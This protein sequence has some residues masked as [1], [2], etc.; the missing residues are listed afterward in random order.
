MRF[1]KTAK[2]IFRTSFYRIARLLLICWQGIVWCANGCGLI[3][4][5]VIKRIDD[6][7]GVIVAAATIAIAILT[8]LYVQY[9][10]E[11]W[12]TMQQQLTLSNDQLKLSHRPW[13]SPVHEII[14]P[15]TFDDRGAT[16][17]MT[18]TLFNVGNSVALNVS[19]WADMFPFE[20][21]AGYPQASSRQKQ[22]CDANRHP[23]PKS[24]SGYV[25]FPNQTVDG[26]VIVG[27]TKKQ[28]L[29]AKS[30][31]KPNRPK[32]IN[33]V[34]VGC[35]HYRSS[36]EPSEAPTHQTRFTYL[37]S[38]SPTEAISG[39]DLSGDQIPLWLIESPT[40]WS[41]D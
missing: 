1:L 15:L 29:E 37:L 8:F 41:A 4:M 2:Q 20:W 40:G 6:H 16:L 36:F 33:L 9:S 25:M 10:K 26:K 39:V 14:T 31:I 34:I 30:F 32:A 17:T 12:K 22:W 28:I 24:T 7:H 27:L 21:T 18:Q 19:S 35:I 38:T 5:G 3:I 11:Q 23:N 13:I